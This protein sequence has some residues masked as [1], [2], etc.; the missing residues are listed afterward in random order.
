MS[1]SDEVPDG[2][3]CA[4]G[5]AVG[6]EEMEINTD[7]ISQVWLQRGEKKWVAA[8]AGPVVGGGFICLK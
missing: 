3:V 8:K 5:T 1:G 4:K 2:R 7:N 6:G